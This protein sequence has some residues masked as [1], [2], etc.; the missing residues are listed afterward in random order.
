M[1]LTIKKLF[2]IVVGASSCWPKFASQT[3]SI[4]KKLNSLKARKICNIQGINKKDQCGRAGIRHKSRSR[5][6][7]WVVS[8]KIRKIEETLKCNRKLYAWKKS[9]APRLKTSLKYRNRPTWSQAG[10][11]TTAV[12]SMK[13]KLKISYPNSA[14]TAQRT[15]T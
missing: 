4:C 12:P 1:S 7:I 15:K 2:L 6:K 5:W 9:K 3:M 13:M 8:L 11:S 10:R 14:N